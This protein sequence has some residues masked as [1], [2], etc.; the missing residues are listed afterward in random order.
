MFEGGRAELGQALPPFGTALVFQAILKRQRV[1]AQT[2][3]Q[4]SNAISLSV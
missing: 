4:F 1:I 3:T 2:Q